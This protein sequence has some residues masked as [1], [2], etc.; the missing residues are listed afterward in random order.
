M[1]YSTNIMRLRHR[2]TLLILAAALS[3]SVQGQSLDTNL[4]ATIQFG[5]DIPKL[6]TDHQFN[7]Q[8]NSFRLRYDYAAILEGGGFDPKGHEVAAGT[9]PY[10][11][12]V[13][14]SVID[15]IHEYPDKSDF[16]EVFGLNICRHLMAKYPQIRRIELVIEIPAYSKVK[17]DRQA[18]LVMVRKPE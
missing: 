17:L 7:G 14:T 15:Y 4:D 9:Y 16:Y 10:F 11:Q 12:E 3:L 1:P 8:K 5:F 13:R 6:R 2:F 18:K